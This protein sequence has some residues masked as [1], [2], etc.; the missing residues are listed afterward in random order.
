MT[1][2]IGVFCMPNLIIG[3]VDASCIELHL[4]EYDIRVA[5]SHLVDLW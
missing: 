5:L 3:E 1:T 2:K 4:M